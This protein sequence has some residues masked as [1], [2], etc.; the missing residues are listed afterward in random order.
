MVDTGGVVYTGGHNKSLN[1]AV[2]INGVKVKAT[3]ESHYGIGAIDVRVR[4]PA[5]V[6]CA[7]RAC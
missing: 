5:S 2:Y 3:Q 7:L 1:H 4:R 6:V